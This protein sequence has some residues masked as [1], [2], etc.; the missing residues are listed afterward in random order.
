MASWYRS[1]TA[2]VAVLA[3]LAVMAGHAQAA[4]QLGL[5]DPGFGAP[6]SSPSAQ[7]A[8]AAMRA[9]NGSV[10]RVEVDWA[11]EA[12]GGATLPSGF[13]PSNPADPHYRWWAV[14]GAVRSVAQLHGQVMLNIVDA[15]R[16]AEGP[17][18]PPY[19]TP[20][21]IYPGAWD[22]N[23]AELAQF[24]HAAAL[25]Y[26]GRFPDQEHPGAKLPRVNY[27]EVWN[28]ENLPLDLAGPD[29]VGEYRTLLN[30]GYSAIKAVHADN[31]IV[32]GGLAPVSYIPPL[33]MP[34]LQFAA[35]VMC[36]HRVGTQFRADKSCPQ[37]AEFDVFAMHP[38]S[39][40][41]TPTKHAYASDNVLVGDMSKIA[42]LVAAAD[43]LHTVAPRI[44]HQIWVT[45]F[46]WFTNPPDK[47]VGDRG[48]VAAR[49]VAYSLY[50]MWRSGVNLVIWQTVRD[51]PSQLFLG[52]GL[53]TAS[54]APKLDLRAYAF[55]FVASV[56]QGSGF[57]WGRAPVS[58]RIRV[59]VQRAH[60]RRWRVVAS[61]RTGS[62]GVFEVRFHARGNGFYRAVAIGGPT[63]LAYDSRPIP[64]RRTHLFNT[65]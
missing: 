11:A 6:A 25:R 36:L 47:L 31:V 44:W 14:D 61:A 4:F 56:K 28:E 50:E 7:T 55:P 43:R 2:L 10:V 26:G 12:P 21:T 29:I 22:P 42:M 65:G 51:T 45:E 35:E 48:P 57:A 34:P 41:A 17:N 54:G 46:A 52:G 64:P 53:Y 49:Y 20:L 30:A 18:R 58:R 3:A 33:S 62:D 59:L 8:D 19:T 15:P 40:A 32:F 60:G 16:W 38:Y 63:S 39:L 9:I 23:A 37:R 5:Q 24:A 13:D 1:A 27:W